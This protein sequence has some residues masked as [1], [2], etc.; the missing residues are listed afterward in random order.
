MYNVMAEHNLSACY[1]GG[2]NKTTVQLT[3]VIMHG[4][5]S[6][7]VTQPPR[8]PMLQDFKVLYPTLTDYDIRYYIFQLL[9]ALDYSHSQVGS[10]HSLAE[11]A[12]VARAAAAVQA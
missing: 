3:C 12:A 4:K 6:V 9:R 10:L 8:I 11:Q 1:G 5:H 7:G 2:S